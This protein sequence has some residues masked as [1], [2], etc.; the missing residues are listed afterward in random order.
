MHTTRRPGSA[1]AADGWAIVICH[2]SDW[3]GIAYVTWWQQD[4]AAEDGTTC[5]LAART[6]VSGTATCPAVM[7]AEVFTR[8]IAL[9][10]A[11][12]VRTQCKFEDVLDDAWAA[13]LEGTP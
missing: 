7:P 1:T 10:A 8:T 4:Q 5:R 11:S 2:D 3:G 9:A 12:F 13:A 6:L